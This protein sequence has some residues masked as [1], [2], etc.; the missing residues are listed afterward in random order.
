LKKEQIIKTLY[1]PKIN[2]LIDRNI[3]NINI[4]YKL[5]NKDERSNIYNDMYI[6]EKQI[7]NFKNK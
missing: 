3:K 6:N 4:P 7:I 1:T 5:S 2:L